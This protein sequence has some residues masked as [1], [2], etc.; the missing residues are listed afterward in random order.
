VTFTV[1][2]GPDAPAH[3]RRVAAEPLARYGAD[4]AERALLA[5]SEL[6]SNVVRHARVSEDE[7]IEISLAATGD[8]VRVEV[9]QRTRLIERS[10]RQVPLKEDGG[11]GLMIVERVTDRWGMEPGPPGR[12]WFEVC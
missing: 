2:V 4:A 6:V 1:R 11:M 5:L 9:R 3:A 7:P 8:R 12:V 10:I